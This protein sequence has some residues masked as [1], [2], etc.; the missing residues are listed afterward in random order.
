MDQF[1]DLDLYMQT[2]AGYIL[3]DEDGNEIIRKKMVE[4]IKVYLDEAD[5]EREKN[6]RV[7]SSISAKEFV[8]TKETTQQDWREYSRDCMELLD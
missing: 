6:Y 7:R 1:S 8:I 5:P 2:T 4:H 3:C